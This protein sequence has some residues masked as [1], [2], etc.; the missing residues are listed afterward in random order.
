MSAQ[1]KLPANHTALHED[2]MMYITGGASV[3]TVVKAVVAVGGLRPEL[4]RRR[5][6]HGPEFP[7]RPAGPVKRASKA[8]SR[9]LLHIHEQSGRAPSPGALPFVR[10][11]SFGRPLPAVQHFRQRKNV[12]ESF[13][14]EDWV[15][16]RLVWWAGLRLLIFSAPVAAGLQKSERGPCS[17]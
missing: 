6:G 4:H 11:C 7:E 13:L 12:S 9:H 16:I 8:Q 17:A 10:L 3:D 2:E 1:M 14:V 15:R 5:A